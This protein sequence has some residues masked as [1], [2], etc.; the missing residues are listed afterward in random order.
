MAF[1]DI[2]GVGSYRSAADIRNGLQVELQARYMYRFELHDVRHGQ[3]HVTATSLCDN[4]IERQRNCACKSPVWTIVASQERSS[5][6]V[7][8]LAACLAC[9]TRTPLEAGSTAGVAQ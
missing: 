1:I 9:L 7:L 2:T 6:S 4:A 5:L 8:V 3:R